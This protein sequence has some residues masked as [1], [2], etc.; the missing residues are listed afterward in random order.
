[1]PNP[2]GFQIP[3][4]S[5]NPLWCSGGSMVP[6][7]PLKSGNMSLKKSSYS[8]LIILYQTSLSLKGQ[9]IHCMELFDFNVYKMCTHQTNCSQICTGFE[10][11]CERIWKGRRVPWS[12]TEGYWNPLHSGFLDPPGEPWKRLECDH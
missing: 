5:W 6:E 12:P 3:R 1:M 11:H 4:G 2:R 9:R 10:W 7:K 8:L